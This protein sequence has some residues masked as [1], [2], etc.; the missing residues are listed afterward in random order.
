MAVHISRRGHTRTMAPENER[1][2][3]RT[4]QEPCARC[5]HARRP[6]PPTRLLPGSCSCVICYLRLQRARPLQRFI[7]GLSSVFSAPT[8]SRYYDNDH[9]GDNNSD[10]NAIRNISTLIHIQAACRQFALGHLKWRKGST[11]RDSS[12]A[13]VLSEYNRNLTRSASF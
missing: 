1:A 10:Y 8:R 9:S 2:N 5:D 11:T 6:Q 13:T 3:A 4:W 12:S 7:T